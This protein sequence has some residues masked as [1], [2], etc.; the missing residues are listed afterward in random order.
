MTYDETLGH[1][2][3]FRR[4][5]RAGARRLCARTGKVSAHHMTASRYVATNQQWRAKTPC[6]KALSGFPPRIG[7][8]LA[9]SSPV[10]YKDIFIASGARAFR[11]K[12]TESGSALT[13]ETAD[14][15]RALGRDVDNAR[16]L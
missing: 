15:S 9:L 10:A 5:H 4:A 1:T 3:A 2:D 11:R 7:T 13:S 6:L 16:R 14:A 12:L 8:D